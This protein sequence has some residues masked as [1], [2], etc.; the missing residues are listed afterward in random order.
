MLEVLAYDGGSPPHG[1]ADRNWQYDADWRQ[2]GR[3]P[4]TGARI[5]TSVSTEKPVIS[6]SPPHGGADRNSQAFAHVHKLHRR[7]LAGARIE[8]LVSHRESLADDVAP[9]RGRG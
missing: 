7:P 3:R 6:M 1:G 9:S 5:E 4:L 2:A 8:T